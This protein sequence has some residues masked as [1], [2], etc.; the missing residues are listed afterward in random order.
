MGDDF[1]LGADNSRIPLEVVAG[2]PAPLGAVLSGDGQVLGHSGK[3]AS[4]P[5]EGGY[6][7]VIPTRR[8]P[9]SEGKGELS[10]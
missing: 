6:T 5:R 7:R 1:P 9:Q 8:K 2:T 4:P 3:R 10:R